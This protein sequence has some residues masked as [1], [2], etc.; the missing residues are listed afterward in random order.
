[1]N[2]YS[3][4]HV[5]YLED[6]KIRPKIRQRYGEDIRYS[7]GLCKDTVEDTVEDTAKIRYSEGLCKD[8]VED[9]DFPEDTVDDTVFSQAGLIITG[10]YT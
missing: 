7:E 6:T 4:E 5:P 1:M 8:T 10:W 9:T 3:T 2:W